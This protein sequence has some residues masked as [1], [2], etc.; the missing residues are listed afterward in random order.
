MAKLIQYKVYVLLFSVFCILFNILNAQTKFKL[1]IHPVSIDTLTISS[2]NL[3]NSFDNKQNCIQY[4]NH[5]PSLLAIKGYAA[6]SV[7][8]VWEDSTSVS[9]KLF[10][11]D[12]YQWLNL[13]VND[14]DYVLL[15]ALGYNMNNFSKQN[16]SSEKLE[17][18]YNDVLNY[19]NNNGY[20]FANIF[21]DSLKITDNNITAHLKIKSGAL[22]HIDTVI[23]EGGAH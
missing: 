3:Q 13:S 7:D 23:I 17:Q 2:L 14:S 4:V 21:L 1:I 11:G 6:A 20:P 12:K 22:Y 19:Y 10:T 5:L 8:S 9:I 15:N 16:F 18:L